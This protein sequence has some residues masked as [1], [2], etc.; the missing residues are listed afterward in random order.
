[1]G[2]KRRGEAELKPN[3]KIY[4]AAASMYFSDNLLWSFLGPY[5]VML[6]AT[7]EQMGLIRSTRN[8][9]QNL[10]Q[11]FWG[12][13]S[14]RFSR[15][16]MVSLGYLSSGIFSVYLLM[17]KSPSQLIIMVIAQS[18]LWSVAVPAWGSLLADYTRLENRGKVLG[19][20]GA[21]SQFSGVL[22]TILVAL[23]TF[24][25]SG[26]MTPSSFIVPLGLA[27]ISAVLGAVLVIFIKEKRRRGKRGSLT[28][29]IVSPL[30]HKNFRNFLII[31]GVNWFSMAF[32]WP[33]FPYVTINVV[34]A[35][36]WQIALIS[37][38]PGLI[39]TVSQPKF[40][41]LID[42]AGRKPFL[43]ASR[44]S[45]SLYPLLY[46]YAQNWLHL[47]GIHMLLSIPLSALMVS[48]SAYVMD[49]APPGLRANFIATVNM[50]LGLST[51]LGSLAGGAFVGYLSNVKAVDNPLFW[52]LMISVILR[53]I[54]S[55][56]LFF[57]KETLDK[58]EMKNS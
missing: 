18:V 53:L 10:L 22:A 51:F 29:I 2:D 30:R 11:V 34:H 33:L 20:V 7:Y 24:I 36:I 13:V 5:A 31:M 23:I 58:T 21:I 16:V 43:V 25:Q 48:F 27:G 52:G 3:L 26:E 39:V 17:L 8:L 1:L 14:E 4:G 9:F 6:G 32:A 37:A 49:S 35:T 46:A 28:R 47:L 44:A 41:D 54:S 42:K 40:G 19:K 50:V 57:I 12:E 45:L 38:L 55:A 15:K 56:G